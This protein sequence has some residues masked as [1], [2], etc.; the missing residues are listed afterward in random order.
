[1]PITCFKIKISKKK[2]IHWAPDKPTLNFYNKLIHLNI[3][4]NRVKWIF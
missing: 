2:N 4:N 1:M 3:K